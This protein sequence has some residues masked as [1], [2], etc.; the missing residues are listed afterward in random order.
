[1][2]KY[3]TEI[4]ATAKQLSKCPDSVTSVKRVDR[5]VFKRNWIE[6]LNFEA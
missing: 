4:R 3:P 6:W 5:P 2:T 1:M